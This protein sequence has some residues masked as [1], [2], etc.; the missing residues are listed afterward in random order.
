MAGLVSSLAA[1]ASSLTAPARA[2]RATAWESEVRGR[3]CNEL[4]FTPPSLVWLIYELRCAR[5]RP[6][7]WTDRI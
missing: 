5:S 3:E 4:G 7:G 2:L 1:A 6:N